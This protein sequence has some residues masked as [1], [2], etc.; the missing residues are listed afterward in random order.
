MLIKRSN[1]TKLINSLEAQGLV[2]RRASSV[3]KRAVDLYLTSKGKT[4][5]AQVFDAA[6]QHDLDTTRALSP[7]ERERLLDYL[8]RISADLRA[9]RQF[10]S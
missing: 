10:E 6:R 9:R 4:A 2:E 8:T 5:L 1:M 3:D 7:A